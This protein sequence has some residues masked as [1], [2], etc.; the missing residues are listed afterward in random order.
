M[1]VKCVRCRKII[2]KRSAY[3]MVLRNLGN[4]QVYRDVVRPADLDKDSIAFHMNGDR[5]CGNAVSTFLLDTV[6]MLGL[7]DGCD[8]SFL[9]RG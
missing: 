7:S 9:A 5:L 4:D 1:L 6:E 2:T 3:A 8:L